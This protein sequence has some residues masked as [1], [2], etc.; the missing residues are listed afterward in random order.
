MS[1][2][3]GESKKSL[4]VL[5][6]TFQIFYNF[7]TKIEGETINAQSKGVSLERQSNKRPKD[8]HDKSQ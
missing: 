2:D 3:H 7:T 5:E 1:A 4:D 8:I 6:Q